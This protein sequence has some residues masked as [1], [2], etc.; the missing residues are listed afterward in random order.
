MCGPISTAASPRN[1]WFK[2]DSPAASAPPR[3]RYDRNQSAARR[4]HHGPWAR[5]SIGGL[6]GVRFCSPCCCS[7]WHCWR[8]SCCRLAP[9]VPFRRRRRSNSCTCRPPHASPTPVLAARHASPG[10]FTGPASSAVEQ[11]RLPD[12]GVRAG[13]SPPLRS[14]R[15]PRHRSVQ[16]FGRRLGGRGAPRAA[17]LRDPQPPTPGRQLGPHRSCRMIIGGPEDATVLATNSRPPTAIGW[18]G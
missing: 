5:Q 1:P 11:R 8:R 16:R 7:I 9:E 18:Y 12:D 6:R 17:G 3:T 14:R 2:P 4:V 13:T 10:A 15:C